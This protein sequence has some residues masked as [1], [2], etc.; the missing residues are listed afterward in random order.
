MKRASSSLTQLQTCLSTTVQI[1]SKSPAGIECASLT[2]LHAPSHSLGLIQ[3]DATL[4]FWMLCRMQILDLCAARPPAR[5]FRHGG[6]FLVPMLRWGGLEAESE[7]LVFLACLQ[8]LRWSGR[9]LEC[10][11]RGLM[12]CVV[13]MG[14]SMFKHRKGVI[15]QQAYAVL[16]KANTAKS[17]GIV[18]GCK[19]LD[20]SGLLRL[21]GW[22]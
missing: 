11:L 12:H 2:I 15:I 8:R 18:T 5:T 1:Q 3:D 9:S 6:V 21:P 7:F 16:I 14:R 19:S 17:Q 10:G 22:E 13:L 4:Q 20:R